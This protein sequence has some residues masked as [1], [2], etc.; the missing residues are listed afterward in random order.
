VFLD[1][2]LEHSLIIISPEK[3]PYFHNWPAMRALES[4]EDHPLL[5]A[6]VRSGRSD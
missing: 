3:N 2:R 5:L 6:S 1:E 4:S